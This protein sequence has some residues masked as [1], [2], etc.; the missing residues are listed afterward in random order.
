MKKKTENTKFL[1]ASTKTNSIQLHIS[2]STAT[3]VK[4]YKEVYQKFMSAMQLYTTI[5]IA[6]LTNDVDGQYQKLAF[7]KSH[8]KKQQHKQTR[9]ESIYKKSTSA[10]IIRKTKDFF[11]I[12]GQINVKNTCLFVNCPVKNGNENNSSLKKISD[13]QNEHQFTRRFLALFM[14]ISTK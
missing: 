10:Q 12:T 14:R 6:K 7:H 13:S 11:T 4:C 3:L 2:F 8:T 1:P 9:N 5:N